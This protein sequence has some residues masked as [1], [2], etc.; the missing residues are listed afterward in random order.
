MSKIRNK[1]GFIGKNGSE[2]V[3]MFMPTKER[4]HFE[5]STEENY[6]AV[7]GQTYEQYKSVM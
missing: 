7:I 5:N 4:G 1:P 2:N 3:L 6:P